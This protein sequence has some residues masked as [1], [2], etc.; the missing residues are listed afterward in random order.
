VIA[1]LAHNLGRWT[2]VL[3]LA[4]STPRAAATIRR[5]DPP[6][7]VCDPRTPDQDRP[8]LDA[9]SACPLALADRLHRSAHA[10]PS[11]PAA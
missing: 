7:A 10:Y 11:A 2:D 9:A 4:D 5:D 1:C 8:T 3:G 6:P